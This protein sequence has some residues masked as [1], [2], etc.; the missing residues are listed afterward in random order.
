MGCVL[1]VGLGVALG[2][3]KKVY[4]VVGDGSFLMKM[5][6]MSTIL[7]YRPKNLRLAI[8]DN[9]CYNSC[10]GQKTNFDQVRGFV[11]NFFPVYSV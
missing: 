9:T 6:S 4:I 10:G 5:G 1:G 8:L 11:E 2:T 7:R 3:K